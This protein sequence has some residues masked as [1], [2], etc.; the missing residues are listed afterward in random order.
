[1]GDLVWEMVPSL[2]L[3]LSIRRGESIVRVLYMAFEEQNP[4]RYN[5]KDTICPQSPA[6]A[7]GKVK[8][9][10]AVCEKQA[11]LLT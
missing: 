11:V 5:V 8:R 10:Q 1:M 9:A 4:S 6:A 7:G 2:R 3:V